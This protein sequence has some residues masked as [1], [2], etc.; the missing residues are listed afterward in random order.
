MKFEFS[1]TIFV[2][3]FGSLQYSQITQPRDH[4]W[5]EKSIAAKVVTACFAIWKRIL[6][7]Y[8]Q[9]HKQNTVISDGTLK[10]GLD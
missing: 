8:G 3:K 1:F 10:A 7:N 9:R 5:K 4:D 2:I 6:E